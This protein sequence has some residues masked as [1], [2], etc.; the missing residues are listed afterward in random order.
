MGIIEIIL[1]LVIIGALIGRGPLAL[2][3]VFD[4]LIG[5]IVLVL[6]FRLFGIY[7]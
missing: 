6:L 3:G 2:G 1:I 5:I 4:L 7:L